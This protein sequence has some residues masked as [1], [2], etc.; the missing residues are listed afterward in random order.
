[1]TDVVAKCFCKNVAKKIYLYDEIYVKC[2]ICQFFANIK[3]PNCVLCE[4]KTLINI[5]HNPFCDKSPY[6]YI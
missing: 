4:C 1:M 6:K 2:D 3:N 5:C